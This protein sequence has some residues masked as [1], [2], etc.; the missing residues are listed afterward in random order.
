MMLSIKRKSISMMRFPV[1]S[2]NYC[3]RLRRRRR[4]RSSSAV[5]VS[6]NA[7]FDTHTFTSSFEFKNGHCRPRVIGHFLEEIQEEVEVV[8]GIAPIR[9]GDSQ[10]KAGIVPT[11]RHI[12]VGFC[13]GIGTICGICLVAAGVYVEACPSQAVSRVDGSGMSRECGIAAEQ[14]CVSVAK[15]PWQPPRR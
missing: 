12:C 3:A 10:T 11:H 6:G 7:W 1:N 9:S 5:M 2:F 14:H 13:V 4:H 8:Q 15:A